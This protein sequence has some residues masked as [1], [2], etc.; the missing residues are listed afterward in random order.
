MTIRFASTQL[1]DFDHAASREWIET[2][3]LGGWCSS[4]ISG[5]HTRRYHGLLVIATR[6]PIGR[7]ENSD[8]LTQY[9]PEHPYMIALYD[10]KE[11]G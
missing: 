7:F 4:T 2:N 9:D 1:R 10:L 5:A 6:P 3:G 8:T 11:R